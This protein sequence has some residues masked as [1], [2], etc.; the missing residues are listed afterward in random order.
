MKNFY[1]TSNLGSPGEAEAL[2]WYCFRT[3]SKRERIAAAHLKLEA[4]LE[5]YS[6]QIS[7]YKKTRTGKK[8]FVE[9]VFPGYVFVR[10]DLSF[11]LRRVLSTRGVSGIVKYGPRIPSLPRVLVETLKANLG[12]EAQPKVLVQDAFKKGDAVSV[13][14]GPFANLSA[15]VQYYMP[16][17]ERVR[18]LVE[19]LGDERQIDLPKSAILPNTSVPDELA[20]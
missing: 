9:A 6:P 12:C 4:S 11:N 2:K 15:V 14:E 7:Y 8:R 1:E 16:A 3:Q 20:M 5:A 17:T 13:V 19:F 10:C 18:I